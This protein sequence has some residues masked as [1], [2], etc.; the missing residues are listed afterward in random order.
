[1]TLTVQA[2]LQEHFE[3]FAQTHPL[4]PYQRAA[5]EAL[6][7][8]R[9]AALG[10]HWRSCPEGHVCGVGNPTVSTCFRKCDPMELRSCGP[11]WTCSTVS[12]DMT[13]FGCTPEL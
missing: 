6:R 8:C 13:L 2:I 7:D 11:G 10:G 5:A 4:A 12:E 9:T 3:A 1:M